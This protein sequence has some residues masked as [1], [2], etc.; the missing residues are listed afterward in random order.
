MSD[1]GQIDLT[2]L[3]LL[4][5]SYKL[6]RMD[7]SKQ[8]TAY[9]EANSSP[10]DSRG[11]VRRRAY[12]REYMR[13]R[14]AAVTDARSQHAKPSSKRNVLTREFRTLSH[15]PSKLRLL[16]MR[17]TERSSIFSMKNSTLVN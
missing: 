10:V 15:Q 11:K 4:A 6:E 14:R 16:S 17:L 13:K 7:A 8:L 5:S 9:P 1:S 3:H 12:M 2:A